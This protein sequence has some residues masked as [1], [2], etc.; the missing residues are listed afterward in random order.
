MSV[1]DVVKKTGHPVCRLPPHRLCAQL[2]PNFAID[3]DSQSSPVR[4]VKT[5]RTNIQPRQLSRGGGASGCLMIVL[6]Q[7][8]T[9]GHTFA[10]R[11]QSRRSR[12]AKR[13]R[14]AAPGCQKVRAPSTH[15]CQRSS[16]TQAGHCYFAWGCFSKISYER[17][18]ARRTGE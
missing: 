2:L 7:T 6:S 5:I 4:V 15:R 17:K 8:T 9:R 13:R 11:T 14:P 12:P 1:T 18:R 3:I 16:S 10:K